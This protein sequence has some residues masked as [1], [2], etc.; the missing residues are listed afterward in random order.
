VAQYQQAIQTAFR[1][2]ADGLAR[3]G[4]I[5]NQMAAQTALVEAATDAYTLED[6]RYREGID[7]FLQ[8]LVAQRVLYTA[9]GTLVATRLIKAQ[10]LVTLYRSL[11][12]DETID[13]VPAPPPGKTAAR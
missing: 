1:D 7:P 12:G 5:N 8:S 9:R 2:V 10:N 6:A 13:G 11:G 3:R 4:T